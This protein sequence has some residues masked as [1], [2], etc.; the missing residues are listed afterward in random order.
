MQTDT[1][2]LLAAYNQ[3]ANRKMNES[4]KTLSAPEWEKNLGGY[5]P[6]IRSLCSH[7]YYWDLTWF[8]RFARGGGFRAAMN[9]LLSR[10][11]S[12]GDLFFPVAGD[13]LAGRDT[14]D[15]LLISFMDELN[16]GDLT[17]ILPL[18]AGKQDG[19][20]DGKQNRKQDGKSYGSLML[21]VFNHQTH[22]RGM[23]SLYLELLGRANDFNS[24]SAYL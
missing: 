2:R 24:L 11:Y 14:L 13:Y 9:P 17:R 8:G 20:Q 6:S 19:K 1:V 23:I 22:H 16:D 7:T 5:F 15:E 12:G 21:H 4:I 18:G 3:A 10:D